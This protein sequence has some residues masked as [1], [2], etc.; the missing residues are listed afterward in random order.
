[1]PEAADHDGTSRVAGN[2]SSHGPHDHRHRYP[3]PLWQRPRCRILGGIH[4][5]VLETE[6]GQMGSVQG[7]SW[8]G[9]KLANRFIFKYSLESVHLSPERNDRSFEIVPAII[10]RIAK[11]LANPRL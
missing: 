3:G 2:R 8:R 6:A 1:M 11:L 7:C 10:I 4:A 9:G 5:G